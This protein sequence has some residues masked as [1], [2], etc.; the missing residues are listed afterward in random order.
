[1][2][3]AT[4]YQCVSSSFPLILTATESTTFLGGY[5]GRLVTNLTT[6]YASGKAS[7]A[8]IWT[9]LNINIKTAVLQMGKHWMNI[10]YVGSNFWSNF[11]YNNWVLMSSELKT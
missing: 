1:M 5:L 4:N 2:G 8:T 9:D 7:Y 11:Q 6:T 3:L 10:N